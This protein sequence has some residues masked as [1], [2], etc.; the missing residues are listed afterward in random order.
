M[1]CFITTFFT[2]LDQHDF[3]EIR[4]NVFLNVSYLTLA[5]SLQ[6]LSPFRFQPL[7]CIFHKPYALTVKNSNLY[8]L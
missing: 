3:K 2:T 8:T 6:H 4:P 1:F 5:F 7:F